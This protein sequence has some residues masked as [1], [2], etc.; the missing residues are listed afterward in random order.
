M[1]DCKAGCIYP[2]CG[3]S[4]VNYCRACNGTCTYGPTCG[5][6]CFGMATIVFI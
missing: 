5:D 4:T 6:F 2:S 3:G 1:S